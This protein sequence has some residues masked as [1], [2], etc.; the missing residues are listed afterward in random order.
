LN[1]TK[2]VLL[3]FM[4]A[5]IFSVNAQVA[6]AKSS[7]MIPEVFIDC[8]RCDFDFIRSEINFVNYVNDRKESDI[9][10]MVTN[11]GTASGGREQTLTFIGQLRFSSKNDTISYTIQKDDTWDD[12]RSKMVKYLKMGLVSYV[13]RTSGATNLTVEHTGLDT[14]SIIKEDKWDNWVFR[15]RIGGMFS[16]EESKQI[17]NLDGKIN[18]DRITEDWKIRI[19]QYIGYHE[20]SYKID[21]KLVKG[22]SMRNDFDGTV[23]KSLTN[24]LSAG[25][26]SG[27]AS[28]T[29]SNNDLSYSV[30]AA[31][32]YNIFPYS[33]SSRRDFRIYYNLGSTHIG[34]IDTTIYNKIEETLINERLGVR[35]E[36]RQPWGQIDMSAEGSHYFHDLTKNQLRFYSSVRIY[37]VK[38]LSFEIRGEFKRIQDQL[39]LSKGETTDSE[40]L[41]EMREL[42]TEYASWIRLGLEYTFGSLYNNIVNPRF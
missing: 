4:M 23:V 3:I 19:S 13:A 17:I 20:E 6:N 36:F 16:D 27:I 15:T 41:L 14:T 7:L 26:M 39:S 35:L 18:A 38:G 33:E 8:N 12:E 11:Q 2:L 30:K 1:L 10:I 28:S 24:H 25:L 22:I 5:P 21:G 9:Y 34:Y 40:I 31:V 32:E 29:Y 37:L 42:Q